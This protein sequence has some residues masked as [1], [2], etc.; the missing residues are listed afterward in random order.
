L[1]QKFHFLPSHQSPV[2]SHFS[3]FTN[4]E[5]FMH[6]LAS[7]QLLALLQISDSMFPTGAF[8]HSFGL[9]SYVQSGIVR[10]AAALR[11]LL[12][13]QLR[14]G[15]PTAD[16]LVCKEAVTACE[17]EDHLRFLDQLLTAAKPAVEQRK[18]S[19]EVGRRLLRSGRSLVGDNARLDALHADVQ[20]GAVVGHHAI[21][22]GLLGA[23]LG[24]SVEA[25]LLAYGYTF[26]A[27]QT[28]AAVRLVPLGQTD[29]LQTIKALWP[30]I[31]AAVGRTMSASFD[32]FGSFMPAL[33][34]RAMQHEYLDGRLFMS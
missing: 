2:T 26:V 20:R 17:D 10:D 27:G 23:A 11:T 31:E 28:S 21:V 1:G 4:I 15:L 8:A 30:D 5:I 14:H 12:R 34:I 19:Q 7:P 25:I 9:E 22:F 13:T 6:A 3:P 29:A 24:L 32:D 18:A 16:M 33:D